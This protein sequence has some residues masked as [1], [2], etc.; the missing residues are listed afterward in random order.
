MRSTLD[1]SAGADSAE[2]ASATPRGFDA[3]SLEKTGVHVRQQAGHAAS[4]AARLHLPPTPPP[5]S[6]RSPPLA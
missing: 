2:A 4:L 5:G 1:D 3:H 6:P